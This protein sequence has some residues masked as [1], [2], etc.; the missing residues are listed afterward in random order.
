MIRNYVLAATI[1]LTGC[2]QSPPELHV[3]GDIINRAVQHAQAQIDAGPQDSA[4][5]P[6]A[7][8]SK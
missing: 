1:G 8:W 4:T 3:D 7:E 6:A 2:A 5:A